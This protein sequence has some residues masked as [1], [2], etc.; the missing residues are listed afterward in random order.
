VGLTISWA[1]KRR[2]SN[3]EM[4]SCWSGRNQTAM[5][6]TAHG[7]HMARNCEQPL[8]AESNPCMTASRKTG[9]S[10]IQLQGNEFCQQ[11][12]ILEEDPKP[13]MRITAL[14]DT[15]I[16]AWWDPEQMTQLFH[17]WNSDLQ[18]WEIISGCCLNCKFVT[19][20]YTVVE[21]TYTNC[22][23]YFCLSRSKIGLSYSAHPERT[24]SFSLLSCIFLFS[25]Q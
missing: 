22:Q 10:V 2:Q 4:C 24:L 23:V 14:A 1:C 17:A 13:Q 6:W 18:N 11:P 20:C 3:R 9:T 8:G 25:S 15:L 21:N 16:S 7:S 19:I 5:V 12:V